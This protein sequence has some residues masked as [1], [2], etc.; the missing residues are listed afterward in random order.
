[1]GGKVTRWRWDGRLPLAVGAKVTVGG[2]REAF[3]DQGMVAR[4]TV[5][6]ANYSD[7]IDN[8]DNIDVFTFFIFF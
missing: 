1:M 3:R 2:G 5:H 7:N 8:I 4:R 6:T